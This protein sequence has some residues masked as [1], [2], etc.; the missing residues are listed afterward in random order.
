MKIIFRITLFLFLLTIVLFESCTKRPFSNLT[1]EGIVYDSLGGNPIAGVTVELRACSG[2]DGRSQCN[3]YEVG[4]STT[5]SN[6]HFIIKSKEARSDRYFI[7]YSNLNY[8][9]ILGG[10]FNISGTNL[11]SPDFTTLFLH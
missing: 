1:Y 11:Q 2:D 8:M 7:R 10:S 4:T 9:K 3:N 5:D 6:G